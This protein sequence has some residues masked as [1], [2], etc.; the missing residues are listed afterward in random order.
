MALVASQVY[1]VRFGAKLPLPIKVQTSIA[2]LRITP[3]EYRPIRPMQKQYHKNFQAKREESSLGNNWREK[4]LVENFKRVKEREDPEYSDI[5]SIFNKV[6]LSNL[7]KLSNDSIVLL[8]KRDEQFRL[9]VSGLLFD[10]AI[11]GSVYANIMAEMAKRIKEVIPEI[12]EDLKISV[13]MF[14]KLYDLNETVLFPDAVDPQFDEKVIKWSGMKDKRKGYA[15]FLTHLYMKELVASDEIV[16]SLNLVFQDLENTISLSKTPQT[17]ENVTQLVE[18][19]FSVANLLKTKNTPIK[20][21]IKDFINRLLTGPKTSLNMR[22][23]FKLEDTLKCV[24]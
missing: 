13:A 5:F 3:V 18:F 24:Q 11:V 4:A 8:Q 6:S 20:S 22:S 19:V 14:P 23:K 12:S 21:L 16:K 1:A 17:E 9:R 7:E 10:K 2:R 15:L